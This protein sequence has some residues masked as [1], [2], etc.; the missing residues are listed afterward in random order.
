MNAKA[1]VAFV[2]VW[3]DHGVGPRPSHSARRFAGERLDEAGCRSNLSFGSRDPQP[4][5]AFRP[6]D[7]A[8]CE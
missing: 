6:I 7:A 1:R 3:S 8:G 4:G 2:P 5:R